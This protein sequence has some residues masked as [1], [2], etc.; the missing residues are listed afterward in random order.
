VASK[1]VMCLVLVLAFSAWAQAICPMMLFPQEAQGCGDHR[2]RPSA[3]T[4]HTTEHECCRGKHT[5]PK[6]EEC[7][8][9]KLSSCK[10]AMSCWAVE[11]EAANAPKLLNTGVEVAVVGHVISADSVAASRIAVLQLSDSRPPNRDVLSFKEDL[12]I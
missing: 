6:H 11:R 10:F 5:Q 2:V 3:V 8:R 1:R 9:T 4:S 7:E 12:R